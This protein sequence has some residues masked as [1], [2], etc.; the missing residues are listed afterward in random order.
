MST[1]IKMSRKAEKP[2][3]NRYLSTL[4][5]KSYDADNLYPQNV[6]KIVLNSKVGLGCMSRYINFIEGNGITDALL[7]QMKVNTNGQT[8]DAIH[9]L[10]SSDLGFYGGFALHVNYNLLGQIVEIQHLPFE[11][12]RLCESDSEGNVTKVLVHPDWTGRLTRGGKVV[13]VTKN[14]CTE[15]NVFNPKRDV[16]M[17]QIINAGGIE[18]YNGQVYY[19][20]RDG[21]MTYPLSKCNAVLRDM[22]TDD[23]LS[24][25]S[26]R[27]V[28]NNFLPAGIIAHFPAKPPID[29]EQDLVE[30][31]PVAKEEFVDYFDM[32]EGMMMGD[33]NSGKLIEIEITDEN[34]MPKF[35]EVPTHN[36]DKD[37]TVTS[38]E[39][40]ESIYCAF[41]QEVFYTIRKGKLGFSGD[42]IKDAENYY[43]RNV[44]KEQR[45]L[46]EA[47]RTLLLNWGNVDNMLP[48]EPTYEALTIQS[49]VE[50]VES[51]SQEMAQ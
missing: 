49:Y 47:Y 3:D 32:I 46:T 15:I 40:Q 11:Q 25:V 51:I 42:V 29:E 34:E 7:S 28:R 27:N 8:L 44:R 18:H 36:Y 16:V 39:V 13:T 10:C 43:A 12:V 2:I 9:S 17:S 48:V 24:N 5:I 35:I 19:F 31:E 23:G 4:G 41:D 50:S 22:S 30:G 6:R 26:H 1:T 20:S 33:K 14:N 45:Y 21:Y 38:D 37:F